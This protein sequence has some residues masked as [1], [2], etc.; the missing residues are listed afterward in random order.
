M[1]NAQRGRLIL[2]EVP[3]G[4]VE[5]KVVILLSKFTK[6]LSIAELNKKVRNTPYALSNDISR[7]KGVLIVE[8]F[9]KV[10][11]TAVFVPHFTP[12][13]AVEE[14][15]PIDSEP[16]FTM[17]ASP[18]ASEKPQPVQQ[19]PKKDGY[20]RVI[21]F[22]ITILLLLSMAYLAYQLW[23]LIGGRVTE[24]V[25]ALKTFIQNLF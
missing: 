20:R 17:S 2:Q 8:A 10:G 14:F 25:S 18:R 19:Q 1:S 13:P 11:A 4:E 5:R 24:W 16:R 23:P 15:K 3:S 22:L 7:E 12:K 21:T 9:Q 6:R